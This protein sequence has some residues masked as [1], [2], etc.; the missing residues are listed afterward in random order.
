MGD[1]QTASAPARAWVPWV[2]VG[3]SGVIVAAAAVMMVLG[4]SA[5]GATWDERIHAVMLDTYFTTGWYASPDWLVD[6]GLDPFLGKWPYFVYAPV[7]SLIG[8]GAAVLAGAE[9]WGGFSDSSAAFTARH[10]GS[11][12]ID[13]LGI[14]GAALIVRVIKRSWR[15]ALVS[16]AVVASTPMWVGH[17]MFNIKDLPVGAGYT[18][19][20]LGFVAICRRDYADSWRLRLTAWGGVAVGTVLAVGTRPASGLPIALAGLGLTFTCLALLWWSRRRLAPVMGGLG[21]RAIDAAGSLVLAYVLLVVIYPNGFIN[22]FRLVKESLLISGRFPVNDPELT[23]GVLLQQPPPWTYLPT[24]FGAQLTLLTI[25]FSLIFAVVWAVVVVR[26]LRTRP[27]DADMLE[28]AVLPVPVFLQA[29]LLPLLAILVHSTMYDA[30]RQFL[31]VV[32]AVAVLA[33]LGIR[34]VVTRLSARR[35]A[36]IAVWTLVAVGLVLPVV[37]QAR[38]FPYNYA[39]FNEVTTLRPVNGNWATDYWRASSQELAT[40]VPP[41]GVTSCIFIDAKHPLRDCAKDSSFA[42]FWSGRGTEA[43]PGTLADGEYWLV[44]ENG[45]D[46]TMPPGCV[47]HDELTRPLR[48]QELVIGQVMRCRLPGE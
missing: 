4:A 24:W 7:A 44:R 26:L 17:G 36:V 16:A 27:V 14:L 43:I 48:G 1:P 5:V 10:L 30:V 20:T 28:S 6:G 39:Y 34:S 37:D 18:L 31:F 35:P 41:E 13:L 3:L 22:P 25:V 9:P 15:W 46:L 38:L 40:L 47:L 45:G 11:A 32:P 19:A 12:L 23:N 29:L 2:I 33:V 8:H 42:P 21:K